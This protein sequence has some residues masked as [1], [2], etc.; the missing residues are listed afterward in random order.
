[1]KK[2]TGLKKRVN[3]NQIHFKA[4]QPMLDQTILY[5]IFST[6][7]FLLDLFSF[8]LSHMLIGTNQIK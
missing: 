7:E 3:K 8:N 2:D 6:Y 1:M 4:D 5:S